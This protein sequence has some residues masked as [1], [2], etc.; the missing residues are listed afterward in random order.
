MGIDVE[1]NETED[2]ASEH[3][4]GGEDEI[5]VGGLSGDLADPQDP[6]VHAPTHEDGGVDEV[7]HNDLAISPTDH[8]SLPKT[9]NQGKITLGD[10]ETFEI[11]RATLPT[12]KQIKVIEAG[13]QPSGVASLVI[14]VYNQTDGA[15][16][17]SNNVSYDDGSYGTPLATGGAGDDIEIRLRNDSGATDDASGWITFVV[18]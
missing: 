3:E 5:N 4:D 12:G 7:A 17:Y 18:E 11:W 15:T 6:K 14:E 8:H 16:I 9:V 2:H 1:R 13:I 10:T